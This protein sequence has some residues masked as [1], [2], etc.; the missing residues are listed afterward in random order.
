VED[1]IMRE[2]KGGATRSNSDGKIEYNGFRHPLVELS[3]G[4]YMNKHQVQ[5]DGKLRS[6]NNWWNGWDKKISLDSLVRHVEDLQAIY[7]GF[8]VIKEMV[9][10]KEITHYL[11]PIQLPFITNNK[12]TVV[13]EEE[14]VNAIRF[15]CGSYL[16]EHLKI[17]K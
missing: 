7:D 11:Q 6:S 4:K 10:K 1:K 14:C 15:N 16:L 8:I 13:S 3:F 2:F 12:T 5:E 9:N 17:K